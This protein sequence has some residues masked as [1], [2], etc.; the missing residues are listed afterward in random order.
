MAGF[1]SGSTQKNPPGFFG[2]VP[3]CLNPVVDAMPISRLIAKLVS[4]VQRLAA[5]STLLHPSHELSE[6]IYHADRTI[7]I[8]VIFLKCMSTPCPEK[9]S[10]EYFRHNFIK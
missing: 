8:V 3:G 1:L 2:Y 5:T 4:L 6:W 7:N 10:L 9:K